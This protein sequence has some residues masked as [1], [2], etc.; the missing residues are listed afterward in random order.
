MMM[1]ALGW[2]ILCIHITRI[3]KFVVTWFVKNK[4]SHQTFIYFKHHTSSSRHPSPPTGAFPQDAIRNGENFITPNLEVFVE[5]DDDTRMWD[6]DISQRGKVKQGFHHPKTNI[7]AL[8][9]WWVGRRVNRNMFRVPRLWDTK[10][11]VDGEGKSGFMT[12][13]GW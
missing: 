5:H 11:D 4:K 8:E 10:Y 3:I 2:E 6:D 13:W 1:F 12:P 9:K 7:F